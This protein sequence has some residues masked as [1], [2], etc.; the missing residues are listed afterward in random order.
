MKSIL[1]VSHHST[2]IAHNEDNMAH[3]KDDMDSLE[4]EDTNVSHKEDVKPSPARPS[5]KKVKIAIQESKESEKSDLEDEEEIENILEVDEKFLQLG[6]SSPKLKFEEHPG[7]SVEQPS[8]NQVSN[9]KAHNGSIRL[10]VIPPT[11]PKA[12]SS[13]TPRQSRR[14]K[15]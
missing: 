9:K 7:N 4:D 8:E 10:K 14:G 5:K 12:S 15:K 2:S 6:D 11:E 1:T 3:N 13:F